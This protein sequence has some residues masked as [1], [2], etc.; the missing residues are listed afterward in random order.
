MRKVLPVEASAALEVRIAAVGIQ[1]T[2]TVVQEAARDTDG[3]TATKRRKTL[4]YERHWPFER[5][6]DCSRIYTEYDSA[7]IEAPNS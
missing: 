2:I 4:Q 5:I 6:F 1:T 7:L 3:V